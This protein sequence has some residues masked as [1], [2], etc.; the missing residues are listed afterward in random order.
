MRFFANSMLPVVPRSSYVS[1]FKHVRS[2]D[3]FLVEFPK[4]GVTWLSF[5]IANLIN[6]ISSVEAEVNFFNII[7]FVPD[8]HMCS[9]E[10][11]EP[12]GCFPGYRILKSH[13][14]VNPFYCKVVYLWRDPG[15]VLL[16]YYRMNVGLG[17]YKKSFSSFVKSRKFG[18]LA[19]RRHVEGWLKKSYIGT[20]MHFISY[21]DLVE[22][23]GVQISAIAKSC[24]WTK[25]SIQSIQ[26]SLDK[27]SF[28]EMKRIEAQSYSRDVRIASHLRVGPGYKF[29]GS[30]AY[31]GSD[32]EINGMKAYARDLNLD[33]LEI[34]RG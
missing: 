9:I 10:H 1:H 4:S 11:R 19:W 16:S 24:G 15:D 2:D 18:A 3:L 5:I 6:D 23:P 27:S 17:V 33:L 25:A 29:V 30:D 7:D 14:A 34:L 21:E 12:A 13:A 8:V 28:P 31:A 32:D 26:R 20:R 22:N